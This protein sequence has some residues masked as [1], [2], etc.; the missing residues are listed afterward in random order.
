[1]KVKIVNKSDLPL[2]VYK[3]K[4]AS[5]VDLQ[6][7]I[8]EE[9][10]LKPSER[11]LIPTGLYMEIPE[12]YE[13]QVRA[14]SGLAIKHGITLINSVGTIDSDYRGELC[15]PLVNLGT[16]DFVI[17]HGDRIAQMIFAKYESVEWELA[18]SVE[19]TERGTGG[20]GSTGL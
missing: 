15:V 5:G 9:I 3:T 10:T 1:M 6:A 14:R 18:D 13:A 11:Q 20:F 8:K 19:D 12:G 4:G 16:E 2:P 17:K 7:N